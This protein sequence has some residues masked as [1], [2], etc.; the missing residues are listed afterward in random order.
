MRIAAVVVSVAIGQLTVTLDALQRTTAVLAGAVLDP[1]GVA[2]A[3]SVVF[4]T[5]VES[6]AQLQFVTGADGRFE[7]SGLA[8]GAY[9]L[10]S[11]TSG[12]G[13][14]ELMLE[15]GD[16]IRRDVV[17]QFGP[18]QEAW[19]ISASSGAGTPRGAAGRDWQCASRGVP[20][21][22]PSSLVAEFER[23]ELE[24]EGEPLLPPRT[25]RMIPMEYPARLRDG[26]IEGRIV[27]T[28]RLGIDGVLTEMRVLSSD[29]PELESSTLDALAHV[30]WEPARLR[31]KPVAVPFTIAI[32][33]TL[34]R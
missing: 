23:D 10:T 9:R 1:D 21:C 29:R 25:T 15:A 16:T 6:G 30:R 34:S 3:D 33:Y 13:R 2:V 11:M 26:R 20:F 4:M 12:F 8:P 32:R 24:R 7:F 22:G 18:F 19:L 17:L 27:V 14:I 31:G 28:G 5:H